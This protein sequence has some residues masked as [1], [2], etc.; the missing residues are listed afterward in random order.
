M[1]MTKP[2]KDFEVDPFKFLS[3]FYPVSIT[4]KGFQF[5]SAEA[6]YQ[7][8]KLDADFNVGMSEWIEEYALAT[9]DKELKP[10]RNKHKNAKLIRELFGQMGPGT[11]KK[12]GRKL[13]KRSD[14]RGIKYVIM[15]EILHI[16]FDVP[17]LADK[18]MNTFPATLIEGNT[19][20]DVYWG[21]CGGFGEN[22][23]GEILMS[24]RSE[25][26]NGEKILGQ[27]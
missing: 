6:A 9:E 7:C 1:T 27:S 3:N 8:S 5:N 20:G 21:V 25:L 23:L 2:I 17:E 16:K 24:I 19:W 15:L 11:A 12:W 14:W 22:R 18:L 26:I 10:F 4:Y 13:P